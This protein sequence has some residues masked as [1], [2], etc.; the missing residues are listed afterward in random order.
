MD[1]I[2]YVDLFLYLREKPEWLAGRGLMVV[3]VPE[4][5][6]CMACVQGKHCLEH[7]A[8]NENLYGKDDM[9]IY[10]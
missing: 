8:L 9:L 1:E 3:K 5:N 4:N 7:L 6:K 2:P 10:W